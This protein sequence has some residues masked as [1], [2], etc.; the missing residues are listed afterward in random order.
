[1][2]AIFALF[3]TMLFSAWVWSLKVELDSL[4]GDKFG[5]QNVKAPQH[6]ASHAVHAAPMMSLAVKPAHAGAVKRSEAGVPTWV[7]DA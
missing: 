3:I 6:H 1:M 5:R 2:N 4:H 7:I